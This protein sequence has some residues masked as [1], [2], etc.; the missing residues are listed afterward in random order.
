MK[1][2]LLM[3]PPEHFHDNRHNNFNAFTSQI[4]STKNNYKACVLDC[5][6][7]SIAFITTA[8]T[9]SCV[10]PQLHAAIKPPLF[11]SCKRKH[12]TSKMYNLKQISSNSIPAVFFPVTRKKFAFLPQ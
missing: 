9:M 10:N 5:I 6:S 1:S 7:I 8:V 2:E 4:L 11:Q 3:N 12:K